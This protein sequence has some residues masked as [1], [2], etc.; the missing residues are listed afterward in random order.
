MSLSFR[1]V[2]KVPL[3]PVLRVCLPPAADLA[4]L[5]GIGFALV[6]PDM[7]ASFAQRATWQQRTATMAIDLAAALALTESSV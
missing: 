1:K 6:I 3:R 7:Q 4:D 2:G 5:Y